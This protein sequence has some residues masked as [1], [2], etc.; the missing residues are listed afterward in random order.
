MARIARY[1]VPDLPH[2]VTQRGHRRERVFF[3]DDDFRLYRTDEQ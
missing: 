1:I 2:H 3:S